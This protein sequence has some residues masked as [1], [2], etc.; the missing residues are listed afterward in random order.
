MARQNLDELEDIE[1]VLIPLRDVPRLLRDGTISHALI[2]AAFAQF[3]LRYPT[4]LN[5]HGG[6]FL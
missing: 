2:V 1:V 4:Y 6:I 3:F 5:D